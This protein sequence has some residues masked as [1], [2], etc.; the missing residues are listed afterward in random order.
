MQGD[1]YD[2]DKVPK[3]GL[4]LINKLYPADLALA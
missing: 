4:F 2:K 3:K 1:G